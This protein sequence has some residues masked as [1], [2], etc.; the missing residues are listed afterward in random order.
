MWQFSQYNF[1]ST[2][3]YLYFG[4]I[5]IPVQ[6]HSDSVTIFTARKRSLRRLLFHIT[7]P[8][9][10]LGLCPG[11]LCL[12]E[13]VRETPHTWMETPPDRGPP[14][15]KP[16]WTEDSPGERPSLDRGP[17]WRETL[18]GQGPPRQNPWTEAPLGRPPRQRPPWTEI[19]GW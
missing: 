10:G 12:G 6:F 15:Q 9:G 16:P 7:C 11:G 18:P 17:A 4:I 19:S 13:S 3:T 14:G 2:C 8:Q 5:S 1:S